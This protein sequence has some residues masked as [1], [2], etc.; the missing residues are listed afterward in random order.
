[1][2]DRVRSVQ[3]RSVS[4]ARRVTVAALNAGR[5]A[6]P[7][8]ALVEVDVTDLLEYVNR[9]DLSFTAGVIACVGRAAA[10]HPDVHAYR[11]WRGR[12][13]THSHVD[14]ST[15]IEIPTSYGHFAL[16]HL[17]RDADIRTIEDLSHGIRHVQRNEDAA[18]RR[19][20][21]AGAAAA[22]V[23]GLFRLIFAAA[24]KSPFMRRRVGT[25]TVTAV[26]MFAGGGGWGVGAPTV[27]SLTVLVGG[28][29][30]KP[31]AGGD[32]VQIRDV[33]D[34]TVTFDHKVIDGAPAARFLADLRRLL[35]SSDH[36]IA[37]RPIG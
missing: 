14:V 35:E 2:S 22:R 4:P 17:L 21:R 28:I 31:L 29:T 5:R 12:L 23:P 27:T 25:V 18:E 33:L 15:L 13:V 26:G 20:V 36:R 7:V 24:R 8:H 1:M 3:R 19:F 11:D 9:R 30:R 37:A 16:G 32:S 34:L 6:S 10:L